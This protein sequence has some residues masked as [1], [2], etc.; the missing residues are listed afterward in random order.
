MRATADVVTP[1][2]DAGDAGVEA[3]DRRQPSAGVHIVR[4]HRAAKAGDRRKEAI[5]AL[6]ARHAAEQRVPHVPVCIDEAREHDPLRPPITWAPGAS[7][8]API[9]TMAPL[10]TCTEPFGMSP[11]C[12][13]MVMTCALVMTNSPRGGSVAAARSKRI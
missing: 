1:G 3:L 9:A 11:S 12:G 7:T 4:G 2:V 8:L 13:S 10:R 6:I 5:L